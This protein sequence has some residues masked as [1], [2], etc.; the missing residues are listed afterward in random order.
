MISQKLS[1][2]TLLPK[3]PTMKK[4]SKGEK[5]EEKVDELIATR[6]ISVKSLHK[7]VTIKL[8]G[9]INEDKKRN[10][11]A[12]EQHLMIDGI[13]KDKL[14]M[15]VMRLQQCVITRLSHLDKLLDIVKNWEKSE[16]LCVVPLLMSLFVGMKEHN[17]KRGILPSN[18]HLMTFNDRMKE[19]IAAFENTTTN[20]NG[21]EMI[22]HTKSDSHSLRSMSNAMFGAN[23]N[24]Q[25]I[26]DKDIIIHN[27]YINANTNTRTT[28][29]VNA[30]NDRLIMKIHKL[31]QMSNKNRNVHFK[32]HK[33]DHANRVIAERYFI[34]NHNSD[35]NSSDNIDTNIN[36]IGVTSSSF[37]HIGVTDKTH[38]YKI[39]KEL[40]EFNAI[41]SM[42]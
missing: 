33:K 23:D 34:D 9:L 17:D 14:N 12:F 39:S 40:N 24:Y 15:H 25:S 16:V 32:S 36:A 31:M 4:R 6:A 1:Y 21:N 13:F 5:K 30:S 27:T 3:Q 10:A 19:Q 42:L 20:P 11:K 37:E 22:P 2:L 7:K 8:Y 38:H 41:Y 26:N 35:T 29:G 28:N 18:R